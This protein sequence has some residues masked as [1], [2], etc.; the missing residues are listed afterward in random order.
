MPTDPNVELHEAREALSRCQ[1]ERDRAR[2]ESRLLR[3]Q[4]RGLRAELAAVKP[5]SQIELEAAQAELEALRSQLEDA[6][7]ARR[8]AEQAQQWAE[9]SAQRAN[10][11]AE[12]MEAESRHA[13]DRIVSLREQL[14]RAEGIVGIERAAA[15]MLRRELEQARREA[16]HSVMGV[17]PAQERRLTQD[18]RDLDA[19]ED[20]VT[21]PAGPSVEE[22]G[23]PQ[24]PQGGDGPALHPQPAFDLPEGSIWFFEGMAEPEHF[25]EIV[26][27][28]AER[29]LGE[30][31]TLGR[32][33][34]GELGVVAVLGPE[35]SATDLLNALW[36]EQDRA[37]AA[38]GLP[39]IR[40]QPSS[41]CSSQRDQRGRAVDPE[42]FE[43]WR[44][45]IVAGELERVE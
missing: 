21:S 12:R 2:A 29:Y 24:E 37:F 15:E 28:I 27:A 20:R 13:F 1:A 6:N 7:Q 23:A 31:L 33:Q 40:V 32:F 10:V 19:N 22:Q 8:A 39:L 43:Q 5:A 9:R 34:D 30:L 4:L 16:T 38:T 25:H 45:R 41:W 44:D 3:E 35:H 14:A 36:R 17:D 11:N 42:R 26:G 18:L